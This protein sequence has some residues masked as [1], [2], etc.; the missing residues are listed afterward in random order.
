MDYR[1]FNDTYY[2]RLDRG[3]ELVA[4]I[5][6]VCTRE[7]VRSA[8]FS[9]IGGCSDAQIQ[10][11]NAEAGSFETEHTEGLLE[12]VSIMGNVISD[13]EGSLSCHAHALFSYREDGQPRIAAG[14]LKS[15]TVRYTAELELRPVVGGAISKK[16]DP[17][18]NTY[19]WHFD[20]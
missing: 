14:H 12:L 8:T 6:D 2:I 15:T 17:E 19:F 9:G 18:T 11:F 20:D 1:K 5:L 4:C 10:V 13:P 16:L 7:G 3:D